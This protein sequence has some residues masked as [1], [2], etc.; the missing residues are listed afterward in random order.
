MALAENVPLFQNRAMLRCSRGLML[1]GLRPQIFSPGH[2]SNQIALAV[3]GVDN[4]TVSIWSQTQGAKLPP[5][6]IIEGNTQP[7]LLI[8]H[9]LIRRLRKPWNSTAPR[10]HEIRVVATH[11]IEFFFT[12]LTIMVFAP[13]L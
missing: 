3:F 5:M 13:R 12:D 4:T 8:F 11:V 1:S 6:L 2:F 9:A 7:V 10:L